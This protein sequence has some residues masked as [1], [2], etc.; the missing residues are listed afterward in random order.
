MNEDN[1][2]VV[3]VHFTAPP[4]GPYDYYLP[5]ELGYASIGFRVRVPLG[6]R[7]VYG[8]IDDTREGKGDYKQVLDVPDVTPFVS[9]RT[10]SLVDFVAQYYAATIGETIRLAVPRRPG[11]PGNDILFVNHD[12]DIASSDED[13]IVNRVIREGWVS[14]DD[15]SNAERRAA[16]AAINDGSLLAEGHATRPNPDTTIVELIAYPKGKRAPKLNAMADELTDKPLNLGNLKES[17]YDYSYVKKAARKS[18]VRI[19]RVL[20][21]E[22]PELTETERR[23]ISLG[24]GNVKQRLD[25]V[26][27]TIRNAG[28]EGGAALVIAPEIYRARALVAR[29]RDIGIVP[30]EYTSAVSQVERYSIFKESKRNTYPL[31]VGTHSA[32]FLPVK[33]LRLIVV[34][35]DFNSAHKQR[36]RAPFYHS[37]ETALMAARPTG[38]AVV[39]CGPAASSEA[40]N[41][42]AEGRWDRISLGKSTAKSSFKIIAMPQVIKKEGGKT[43]LSSDAVSSVKKA[44]GNGKTALFL[45]NRRGFVP[46]V[47]CSNCGFTFRCIDCDANLVYHRDRGALLCHFCGRSEPLPKRCP[48]CHKPALIGYG[49]GTETVEGSVKSL[50]PETNVV[51]VDG[52]TM[53]KA[54]F[55]SDFWKS[56]EAGDV[57][58]IVG[59]TMALRAVYSDNLGA[60][61]LVNADAALSYPDFRAAERTYQTI[62]FILDNMPDDAE[63]ALQTFY[64]GHYS[65]KTALTGDEKEFWNRELPLRKRFGLPPYNRLV[66][67]YVEGVDREIV[68]EEAENTARA[69]RGIFGKSGTVEGPVPA[70]VSR[71]KGNFRSQILIKTDAPT[72]YKRG[73]ELAALRKPKRKRKPA[74]TIVVDPIEFIKKDAPDEE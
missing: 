49:V 14:T 22:E 59:T 60:I 35:D 52:D 62:R 50:F 6:K 63:L 43:V 16:V 57:D 19:Y 55:K 27:E 25:Y 8:V 37:R 10:R 18:I 5:P 40:A 9:L 7:E 21:P 72:I 51:R 46:I 1:R 28:V 41:A 58:I 42:V 53:G 29:F 11:D 13:D 15:L 4:F 73:T 74:V 36:D 26:A 2:P 71:I 32:L 45:I 39:F 24:G 23:V 67:V 47:Y 65:V 20:E 31:I 61:V 33:R 30:I 44:M 17:G 64:E 48:S 66:A 69:I 3:S 70:A 56:Y 12:K 38:A 54:T 34:L 68:D